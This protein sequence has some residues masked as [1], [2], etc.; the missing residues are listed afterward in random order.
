MRKPPPVGARPGPAAQVFLVGMQPFATT[1][2]GVPI[3]LVL[4]CDCL[5]CQRPQGCIERC[6]TAAGVDPLGR[7]TA[8]RRKIT[9]R[10]NTSQLF[11]STEPQGARP[12][13]QSA[14]ALQ[15]PQQ[16]L[17]PDCAYTGPEPWPAP[18]QQASEGQRS[19]SSTANMMANYSQEQRMVTKCKPR[20]VQTTRSP[21]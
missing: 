14:A 15:R 1:L 17:A 2:F 9:C 13:R 6:K 12:H 4:K 20:Q 21:S 19:G 18:R 3:P 10:Y 11:T 8:K 7:A 16:W 5:Y